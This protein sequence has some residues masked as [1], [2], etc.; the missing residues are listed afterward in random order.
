M[1]KKKHRFLW[2]YKS[3]GEKAFFVFNATFM[4]LI[5]L[6]F[7]LPFL[8]VL[9]TSFLSEAE[10]SVR[11]AFVLIPENPDL[12][13]YRMLL[14]RGSYIYR[15]Y[16]VTILRVV[17]GTALSLIFTAT[18]AYALSKKSLPGRNFFILLVFITMIISGGLVPNYLLYKSIHINNSFWVMVLPFL[19]NP[20]WMLIMRNFFAEIPHELEES[21]EIDGCTPLKTLVRIILPLS[22]PS[23]ATIGLFYAVM[24]WNEWFNPSLFIDDARWHPVQVLLRKI[25]MVA[26][27]EGMNND[28]ITAM[29]SKPPSASLKAATM[30]VS[31]VPILCIYPFLQKYL[32][33]G[34]LVGSVKG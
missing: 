32:V 16:F 20:W 31:T 25:V 4:I 23:M 17:V 30:I 6:C 12:G 2:Q 24:H 28:V 13:A 8:I 19:I 27:S 5:S 1:E 33:K 9:G 3:R 26:T 29:G 22:V 15:A 11:G 14:D 34:M 21:A 18:M 7:I 10:V